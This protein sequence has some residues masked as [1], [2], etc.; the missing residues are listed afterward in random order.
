[1]TKPAQNCPVCGKRAKGRQ[2]LKA[3]MRDQ[4]AEE[5]KDAGLMA[6]ADEVAQEMRKDV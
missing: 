2:G 4:H 3:H 5:C 6:I 1:M